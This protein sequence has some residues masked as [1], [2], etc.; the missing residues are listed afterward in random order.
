MS[1]VIFFTKPGCLT[2][3]KQIGILQEAGHMV[4]VRSLLDHP[5]TTDELSS[6]FGELPVSQWFNPNAP[7]IK[8]GEVDP[9]A[10]DGP[11][12]LAAMLQDPLLIR[13]PLLQVGSH[14]KCG[15]DLE[16][17][18]AWIGVAPQALARHDDLQSCSSA[19]AECAT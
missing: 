17:I 8:T 10:Y 15:F 13:R 11:A 5:W 6:F 12:A 2:G 18:D 3:L 14:K 7:R 4:E 9:A 16:E 1:Q 19:T